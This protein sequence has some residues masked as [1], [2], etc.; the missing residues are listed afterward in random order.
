MKTCPRPLAFVLSGGSGLG[1][2]QVGMLQAL[3]EHGIVP[4]LLVGT[5]VGALTAAYVGREYS[6]ARVADLA[7]IWAGLRTRDVFGRLGWKSLL[8][9]AWRGGPLASNTALRTLVETH[10]PGS[11]TELA[12]PTVVVATDL[13][14]GE[15]VLLSEGNLHRNVLASAAIPGIFPP[16]LLPSAHACSRT[17][18]W[19]PMCP[20]YRPC[21]L[22]PGPSW[23]SIP[24]IPVWYPFCR[25]ALSGIPSTC[26]P[27]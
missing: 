10:L 24:G 21:M 6:H 16:V 8:R 27:Y 19:R 1:A 12:I 15:A 3:Q 2:I 22:G 11:H 20:S 4:D 18:G 7:S 25:A 13:I 17:A 26:S 5:S 9:L 23:C 14:S